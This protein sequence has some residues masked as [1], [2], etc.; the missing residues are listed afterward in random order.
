MAWPP[1]PLPTNRTNATPQQNTHPG[2]HNAIAQAINDTVS[3]VNVMLDNAVRAAVVQTT[4]NAS[5]ETWIPF[6]SPFPQSVF[7]IALTDYS[8]PGFGAINLRLSQLNIN[9]FGFYALNPV[10]GVYAVLTMQVSY[11]AYGR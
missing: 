11:V 8:P 2:D 6:A 1:A 10:G 9:G 5:G 3:H 4:T 7:A